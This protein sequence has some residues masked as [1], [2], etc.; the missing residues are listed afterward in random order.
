MDALLDPRRDRRTDH[1]TT[2]DDRR[3]TMHASTQLRLFQAQRH[4]RDDL[5][6]ASQA[7]LLRAERTTEAAPLRARIGRSLIRFGERLADGAHL[8][9]AR[10]R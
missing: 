2:T 1:L 7:R 4:R 9:P 10:P 3:P 8:E 6:A 5:R